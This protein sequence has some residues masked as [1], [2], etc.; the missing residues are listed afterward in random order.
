MWHGAL[1]NDGFRRAWLSEVA[2]A[3]D[4]AWRPQLGAPSFASRRETMIESMADAV[5]QHL[6]LDLI[7]GGTR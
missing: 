4:S 1:E 5:E 3:S 7:I 6:D 2:E